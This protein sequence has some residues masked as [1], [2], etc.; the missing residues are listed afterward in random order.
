[1]GED[2]AIEI[3]KHV[4]LVRKFSGIYSTTEI[5]HEAIDTI[6]DLYNKEKEKNKKLSQCHLQ[7]EEMTG[8]DL[9]LPDKLNV[10]SK[11]K[12][13]EKIENLEKRYENEKSALGLRYS[14][15]G[16]INGKINVLKELLDMR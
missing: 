10:I 15:S 11:D 16:F 5:I 1:M 6:L 12:I 2:E 8:V 9:L 14:E 3:L 4:N 7:Y 13:R